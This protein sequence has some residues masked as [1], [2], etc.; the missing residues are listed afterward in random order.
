M[1]KVQPPWIYENFVRD[2]AS[3]PDITLVVN[4]MVGIFPGKA[5]I[6]LSLSWMRPI[7]SL[8]NILEQKKQVLN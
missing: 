5:R 8:K 7:V 4:Y 3:V 6:K 1:S 2:V